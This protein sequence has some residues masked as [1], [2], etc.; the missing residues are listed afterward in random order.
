MSP[1][2]AMMAGPRMLW[3]IRFPPIT[4]PTRGA[5]LGR[6]CP[7]GLRLGPLPACSGAPQRSPAEGLNA[8]PGRSVRG[9]VRAR[10][11]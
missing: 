7:A 3:S 1:S 11:G 2:M 4:K 8:E 9:A 5:A 10:I 6:Y